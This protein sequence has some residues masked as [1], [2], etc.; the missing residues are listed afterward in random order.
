MNKWD[1][2]RIAYKE[3]E[4]QVRAADEIIN[5]MARM[6]R[7]KLHKVPGSVL[8]DLKRELRDFNI[9]TKEWTP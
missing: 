4:T 5:D 3:A 9:H 7:G 6:I 8:A 2:M 1:E